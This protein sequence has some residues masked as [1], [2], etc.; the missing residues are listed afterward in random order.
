[1]NI[2][3]ETN[4]KFAFVISLNIFLLVFDI[5]KNSEICSFPHSNY[6]APWELVFNAWQYHNQV[7]VSSTTDLRK[8]LLHV[9]IWLF[10][11]SSCD[12]KNL[13]WIFIPYNVL[14]NKLCFLYPWASGEPLARG[15]KTHNTFHN[16][17]YGM[18]IHLRSYISDTLTVF[19]SV[20]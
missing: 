8:S 20:V 6:A 14:W 17:S 11:V 1:M 9:V 12:K 15:Y 13:K 10:R 2:R 19:W 5:F 16:T 4:G 7:T 18:K 3:R